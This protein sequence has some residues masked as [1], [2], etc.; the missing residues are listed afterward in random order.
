MIIISSPDPSH[1]DYD[2]YHDNVGDGG[3]DDTSS[4]AA[5]CCRKRIIIGSPD[6]S[7]QHQ[8]FHSPVGGD[9]LPRID[10]TV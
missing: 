6:L 4:E 3:D 9:D 1:D 10:K 7:H 8:T 5:L 2:D